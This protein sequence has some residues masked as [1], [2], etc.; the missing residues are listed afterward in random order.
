V[1]GHGDHCGRA[2]K[3]VVAFHAADYPAVLDIL[4]IDIYEPPLNQCLIWLEVIF[5]IYVMERISGP[6]KGI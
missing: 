5:I 4:Q 1:C 2:T 3:D 6:F